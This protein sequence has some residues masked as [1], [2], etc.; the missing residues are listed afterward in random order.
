MSISGPCLWLSSL[1][2][3]ISSHLSTITSHFSTS[4]G[5]AEPIQSPPIPDSSGL[6]GSWERGGCST[7]DL[8]S[9]M[10]PSAPKAENALPRPDSTAIPSH[11]EHGESQIMKNAE[12]PEL[13]SK[14]DTPL[15]RIKLPK[16]NCSEP[17]LSMSR[18]TNHLSHLGGPTQ[19]PNE[20]NRDGRQEKESLEETTPSDEG[21]GSSTGFEQPRSAADKKKMKRFR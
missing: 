11:A 7:K 4:S 18:D 3:P 6:P 2:P 8:P 21:M 16:L 14:H 19:D 10:Q 12:T 13:G 5:S 17:H 1:T 9:E 20:E 15:S